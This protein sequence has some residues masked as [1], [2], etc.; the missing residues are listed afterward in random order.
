MLHVRGN[1]AYTS[2]P[3]IGS[4]YHYIY[5]MENGAYAPLSLVVVR[6]NGVSTPLSL[7]VDILGYGY[8]L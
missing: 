2:L 1:E 3:L 8:T 5:S 7:V 6:A 4:K